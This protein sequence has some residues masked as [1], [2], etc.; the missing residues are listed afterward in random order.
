MC[1]VR[2]SDGRTGNDGTVAVP[3][4]DE[5]GIP[6][7]LAWF[8]VLGDMYPVAAG[9]RFFAAGDIAGNVFLLRCAID[10]TRYAEGA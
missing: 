5:K 10:R 3:E 2:T 9:S 4:L 7:L 8:A 1:L 6:S